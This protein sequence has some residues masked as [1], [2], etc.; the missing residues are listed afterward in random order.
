MQE[1]VTKRSGDDIAAARKAYD[2]LTDEEKKQVTNYRTLLAV[3][4]AYADILK[5]AAKISE[6]YFSIAL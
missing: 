2:S 6:T 1:T 3:E 4:K 5:K